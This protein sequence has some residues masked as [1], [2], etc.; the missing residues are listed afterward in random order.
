MPGKRERL[1]YAP[2]FQDSEA[3]QLQLGLIPEEMEDK[4]FIFFEEGWLNFHRSWTGHCIFSMRL[5]G[6]PAGVRT[7][8]V[9]VNRNMDQY[10]SQGS[11]A[12]IELLD[13][14]IKNYLLSR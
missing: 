2:F 1:D 7:I 14:L 13:G 5:E 4:W 3:D 9:W 8:E 6:S 11:T 12:D 10:N